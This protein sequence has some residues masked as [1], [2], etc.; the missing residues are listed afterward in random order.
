MLRDIQTELKKLKYKGTDIGKCIADGAN[1]SFGLEETFSYYS[2]TISDFSILYPLENVNETCLSEESLYTDDS[3]DSNEWGS[4]SGSESEDPTFVLDTSQK[5]GI[6]NAPILS[7]SCADRPA[8]V[9]EYN[10]RPR[11]AISYENEEVGA[12]QCLPDP[13]TLSD[14]I[15]NLTRSTPQLPKIRRLP[16]SGKTATF[17]CDE[18]D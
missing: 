6:G 11:K 12:M 13:K 5:L 9:Y 8:H 18:E 14:L 16:R 17:S 2:N 1:K 10:L 4:G 7:T 3:S 15:F